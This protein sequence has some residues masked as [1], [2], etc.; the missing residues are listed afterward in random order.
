MIK[1]R[2]VTY[3]KLLVM[4]WML[5]FRTRI[6]N[7][8]ELERILILTWNVIFRRQMI[9]C[10]LRISCIWLRTK[11]KYDK[12][13]IRVMKIETIVIVV[14]IIVKSINLIDKIVIVTII[15]RSTTS[16]FFN[17]NIFLQIDIIIRIQF[18][19]IKIFNLVNLSKIT[20]N[21]VL[22]SQLSC[23]LQDNYYFSKSKANQIRIKIRNKRTS[24]TSKDF[25]NSMK[26]K[27]F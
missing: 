4:S 22:N 5:I 18:I 19:K 26:L 27:S 2:L 9:L 20:H 11:R 3:S 15:Y 1:N 25:K 12:N 10:R 14:L 21:N 6:N 8:L 13:F 23:Q 17:L 16:M 7:S 24:R